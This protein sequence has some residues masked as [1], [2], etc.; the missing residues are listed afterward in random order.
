MAEPV[1]KIQQ[2]KGAK[3]PTRTA[4]TFILLSRNTPVVI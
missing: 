1:G 2:G 4:H 3:F